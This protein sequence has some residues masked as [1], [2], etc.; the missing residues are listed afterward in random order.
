M[1][2]RNQREIGMEEVRDE[3]EEPDRGWSDRNDS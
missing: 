2:S 1:E 3:E